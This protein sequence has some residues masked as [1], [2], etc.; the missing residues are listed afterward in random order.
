[1]QIVLGISEGSWVDI[2]VVVVPI[3]L[4][5]LGTFA[6]L[7]IKSKIMVDVKKEI[8]EEIAPL[9]KS[10][11]DYERDIKELKKDEL[12][13]IKKDINDIKREQDVMNSILSTLVKTLDRNHE[14]AS[15]NHLEI[16]ELMRDRD[17]SHK[18]NFILLFEK[19]DKKQDKK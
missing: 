14:E 15:R 9:K 13:P 19:L 17:K 6:Y 2:G 7:K 16:K 5:G 3:I 10:M 1:M 4:L 8:D 18:E 12:E 11:D